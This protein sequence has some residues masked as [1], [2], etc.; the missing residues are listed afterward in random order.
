MPEIEIRP[1]DALDI[2]TLIA[3]DHSISTDVVWQ[4]DLK[5]DRD[6]RKVEVKFQQVRL[7][8]KV[9]Y[10]YPKSVKALLSDWQRFSGL[11]VATIADQ[12]VAYT[13]LVL[14]RI[15]QATWVTDLVVDRSSRRQGVGSTLLLASAEF[16]LENESHTLILE[17]QPKNGPAIALA[18][19]M[20]FDF[21]GFNDHYFP[22][23]EIGIF[24]RKSF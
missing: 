11:L 10:Q 5:Q 12:P 9:K 17:M 2:E 1:A 8:R 23:N 4:M 13:S 16:A 6:L 18:L 3:L 15:T 22:A 19:K 7:P 14:D 24:F 21:C 20:G